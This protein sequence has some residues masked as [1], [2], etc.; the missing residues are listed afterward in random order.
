M[1]L[2]K[3]LKSLRCRVALTVEREAERNL[4]LLARQTHEVMTKWEWQNLPKKKA[5]AIARAISDARVHAT[6]L[7]AASCLDERVLRRRTGQ[8]I[9]LKI[10]KD[11]LALQEQILNLFASGSAPRRGFVYVAWSV[12]PE[13]FYYVGKAKGIKRLSL[14][15]HGKLARATAPGHATHLSL[16][17]PA[18]SRERVLRDVEASILRLVAYDKGRLPWLNGKHEAVPHHAMNEFLD[19]LA[20]FFDDLS[21]SLGRA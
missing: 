3:K 8:I 6:T 2:E 21:L 4:L 10:K 16:V 7:D 17:F 15:S 19:G 20:S 11:L 13:H 18:Q 12:R 9:D 1:A 5:Q 14:A